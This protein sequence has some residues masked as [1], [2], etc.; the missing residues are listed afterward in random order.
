MNEVSDLFPFEHYCSCYE[1]RY[2]QL[3][4]DTRGDVQ[5]A[6]RET[7]GGVMC[8]VNTVATL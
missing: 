2:V 1:L 3:T 7:D 8:R 5:E 6:A 4:T